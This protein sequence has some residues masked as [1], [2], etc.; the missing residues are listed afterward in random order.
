MEQN[1]LAHGH[2]IP[3]KHEPPKNHC[4]ACGKDNPDGMH[5][6]FYLDE[7]IRKTI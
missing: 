6:Q 3:G 7:E 1:K 5:L 4:F 2:E